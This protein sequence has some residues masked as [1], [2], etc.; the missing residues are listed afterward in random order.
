M[1]IRY[2]KILQIFLIKYWNTW[3][4][5]FFIQAGLYRFAWDKFNRNIVFAKKKK[6]HFQ[7]SISIFVINYRY[8]GSVYMLWRFLPERQLQVNQLPQW[9]Q[10]QVQG[11]VPLVCTRRSEHHIFL[12]CLVWYWGIQGWTLYRFW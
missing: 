2:F 11:L 10:Q 5:F 9:L 4:T 7:F 6:M 3:Y 12:Q 8:P 1:K